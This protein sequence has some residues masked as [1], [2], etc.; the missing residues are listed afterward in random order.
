MPQLTPGMKV[1]QVLAQVAT[2][3]STQN[4]SSIDQLG[5][6][7]FTFVGCFETPAANNQAQLQGSPD[8]S[9]W[10][11]IGSPVGDGTHGIFTIDD[12]EPNPLYRYFRVQAL[13]GTS[14]VLGDIYALQYGAKV[15]PVTQPSN[16][17]L[18]ALVGQ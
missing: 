14:T 6:E 8:N 7:G 5:F 1:S 18:A 10:N 3:T 13:R 15:E 16:V 4:S 12:Y 2:G 17:A 11:N 9:T